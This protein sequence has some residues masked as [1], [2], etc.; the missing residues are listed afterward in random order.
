MSVSDRDSQVV[1]I[2]GAGYLGSVLTSQL[3]EQGNNVHVFDTFQFGEQSLAHLRDFQNFHITQGDIRDITA[4]TDCIKDAHGVVLLASL[5]GEPACDR[6]SKETVD[7]NYI[8]TKA[9]AEACRYY[10]VPRFIYA[11]TDSAYGIQEGTMYEESPLNPI[12]LY[13]RLKMQ[14]EEEILDLQTSTFR[15]TV[16]RMATIYGLSPRMRFDL[17]INTLT[18]NAYTRRKVTIYGG[19][20]WRPLVHVVDAARAYSM[21]L[22]K[23]LDASA[24]QIFNVGSNEQN[25]Q[26]SQLGDLIKDVLPEIEVETVPQTPDLRDYH[27]CFDKITDTLGYQTTRSVADGIL[28]IYS[29][30]DA[31]MFT[32]H[33]DRRYYNVS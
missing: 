11:S 15:P 30:F 8:A 18:M 7:I 23:P 33:T 1:V 26:V 4:V 20:Q 22:E 12:S 2:G 14:T 5:V 31:Q 25:Y 24:G 17:I 21:C 3:V 16:L 19:Q 28:E 32:D 27:V 13:T 29:A 9:V 6:D 10:E